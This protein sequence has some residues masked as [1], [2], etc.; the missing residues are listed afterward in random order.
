MEGSLRIVAGAHRGRHLLSPGRGEDVRPTTERVR[1]A[2]FSML[3][4]LEGRVLDLYCGSGAYGLEAI[5]RGAAHATLVD[6]SPGLAGENAA[7][8]GLD[9]ETEIVAADAIGW[10]GRTTPPAGGGFDLVLCDPPYRLAAL[11]GS[12]LDKVLPSHLG[13]GARVVCESARGA[14]I[15]L[16]LELMRERSYGRTTIRIYAAP[17]AR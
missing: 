1:E 15:D 5:S 9:A 7:R 12:E 13:P 3:G 16:G 17:E 14:P 11:I 2:V 10:L 4:P 6:R 8:L